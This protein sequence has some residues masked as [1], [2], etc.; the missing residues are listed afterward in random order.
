MAVI[1][2]TITQSPMQLVSGIPISVTLEPSQP[3]TIFYTLDGSDPTSSSF[4][5]FEPI[6]LKAFGESVTLKFF[7]TDGINTSPIFTELYAPNITG[8]RQPH[9]Q[10]ISNQDPFL[11]RATFPFGSSVAELNPDIVYGNTAGPIVD[12]GQ[13]P[14][15]LDGYDGTATATPAGYV[16]L[17]T[18]QFE[19]LFS[20]TNSIGQ[21]GK[22]IG[23]L[24]ANVI[25]IKPRIDNKVQQ[26]SS[27]SDKLFNP[28]ALVIYQDGTNPNQPDFP[29]INRAHF[30][31]ESPTK[32]DGSGLNPENLTSSG[33]FVKSHYN[34]TDNTVTYYYYDNR[35]GRWIISKEP[36]VQKN[37][38][39]GNL[40]GLVWRT[41]RDK[42]LGFVFKWN[43]WNYHVNI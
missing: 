16:K 8:A 6:S 30:D 11:N 1:N 4:V 41:S 19:F 20:E 3:S 28:K 29:I 18:S 26:S 24:P 31:L 38:N 37:P 2:I 15:I 34:P 40:S 22:G 33:T 32:R 23:T 14:R 12:N 7:A 13:P 27:T 35:V 9:D 42:G 21:Y 39:L 5:Y 43:M 36:Y 17:P 25:Y 10:I